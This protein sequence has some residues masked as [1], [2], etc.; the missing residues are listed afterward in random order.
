MAYRLKLFSAAALCFAF[1]IAFAT[2]ISLSRTVTSKL[3]SMKVGD[4]LRIDKFPISAAGATTIVFHPAKVYSDD[5]RL[6]VQTASGTQEIPRSNRIFL[7]GYS[8]DGTARVAMS[9]N[10]DGSFAE[11][12][13]DGPDGSFA[14]TSNGKGVLSAKRLESTIPSTT[15]LDF[16]CGNETASM[17]VSADSLERSLGLSV[18]KPNVIDATQALKLAMVAVDTDS[19]FMSKLFSN[20]TTTAGNWIASMFNA[21]NTMYERDLSVEL[22][23]G[24]TIFRTNPTTDPY[25]SAS[26]VPADGTDLDIFGAYWKANESAV[27]RSFA[28]LLSGRGPCSGNSCSASGIAW[29]D[30]YCQK[31]F[32]GNGSDTIGSYSVVQV[33]SSISIDPQASIAARLTGHELG[34]NFGAYHT[35][36]TNASTGAAPTGSNTIDK[37]VSGEVDNNV[38]C[39]SGATSCPMTGGTVT[40]G[41]IM[42][43]CNIKGC[44][45]AGSQN[46]LQFHPAQISVLSANIS[47]ESA[48]INSNDTIFDNGFD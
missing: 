3:V 23:E 11:G 34:H 17:A 28:T 26:D 1:H 38:A 31:G 30:Q 29:I 5:A 16:Q 36:C 41:T 46:L 13:G 43:Y 8:D 33:F 7:R 19:L 18:P 14:L 9:L 39:Y 35:H 12:S 4:Q 32:I 24:T 27:P 15:K 47:A 25:T 10:P 37:C 40:A 44:P 6:Y 20:N 22:L 45:T 21:M 48:C 2:D 42:S